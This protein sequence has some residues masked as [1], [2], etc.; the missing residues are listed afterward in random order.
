MDGLRA[1]QYQA[2][3]VAVAPAVRYLGK[4]V[5]RLEETRMPCHG[6]LQRAAQRAH[7]AMVDLKFRLDMLAADAREAVPSPP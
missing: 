5:K 1:W 4:L 7:L 2:M 6:E 3:S